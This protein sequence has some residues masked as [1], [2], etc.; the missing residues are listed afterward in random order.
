MYDVLLFFVIFILMLRRPP[1]STLTDTLFPY[2]T[3]FRSLRLHRPL[4]ATGDL[5]CRSK[6]G[7]V[8][9][10]GAGKPVLMQYE[11]ELIDA[12]NG[13]PVATIEEVYVLRGAGG[14]GG[15]NQTVRAPL[16]T[17]SVRIDLK[18]VVLGKSSS[19][20]GSIRGGWDV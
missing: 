10:K 17:V 16:Q 7:A 18:Y 1:R 19:C 11:R 5:I 15:V 8:A 2:T 13:V 12:E 20:G 3:L 4:S 14:Y 6:V 9:D